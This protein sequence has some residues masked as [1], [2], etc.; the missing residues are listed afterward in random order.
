MADV[1]KTTPVADGHTEVGPVIAA[2][3]AGLPTKA[4]VRAVLLPHPLVA[5]TERVPLIK[6]EGT[7]RVMPVPVLV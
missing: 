7:S 3:V 4:R 5:I 2:G 6:P 1:L